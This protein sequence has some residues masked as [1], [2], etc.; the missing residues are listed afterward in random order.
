MRDRIQFK[1]APDHVV[2]DPEKGEPLVPVPKWSGKD[3]APEVGSRVTIT[4]NGWK[5]GGGP[6]DRG[7]IPGTVIGYRADAGWLMAVVEADFAPH[8]YEAKYNRVGV[9]A[10][11][12]LEPL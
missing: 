6:T 10:G 2:Y 1:E 12:E 5:I 3:Y 8:W 11:R 9:F 7:D 4:L